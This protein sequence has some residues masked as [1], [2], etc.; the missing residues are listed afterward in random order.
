VAA[1]LAV[2]WPAA[3]TD[4]RPRI[5]TWPATGSTIPLNAIV[6]LRGSGGDRELVAYIDQRRPALSCDKQLIPLR[7]EDLYVA[8]YEAEAKL[9][10]VRPLPPHA[11]C[12]LIMRKPGPAPVTWGDWATRTLSP[13]TPWWMTSSR[14]DHHRP[15]WSAPPRPTGEPRGSLPG[16][17][18]A[19][20]K[21]STPVEDAEG[22]VL[23]RVLRDTG[24]G[25][26]DFLLLPRDASIEIAEHACG[27]AFE[28][29]PD[30]HYRAT[31]FALDAAG[32]ET[33]APGAHVEILVP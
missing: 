16:Y 26:D 2:S 10:P 4:C 5:A 22:P 33:R 24:D 15:Q 14:A 13:V 31:L 7:M 17:A 27:G 28:L 23:V 18:P 12:E 32:N 29:E 20:F 19:T 21:I 1:A 9:V 11:R 6:V 30:S 3:A 8:H 25:K